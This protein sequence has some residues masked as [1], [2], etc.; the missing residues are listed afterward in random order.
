MTQQYTNTTGVGLSVA[1][2]LA[3]DSYAY[4]NDPF[5]I[6]ATSLL[7]PVRQ[8]IL[9][10]RMPEEDTPVT[11]LINV[12]ASRMGT[13]IH[14]S[15]EKVW[16]NNYREN[17][18]KLGYPKRVIDLVRVN[19]TPE[20]IKQYE[21][22][23][24]EIL[25][26]YTELRTKR[27]LGKWTISGEL[28]FCAEGAL[29]DFKSTKVYTYI[30]GTNDTK[31]PLQGSIYR[32]LNPIIVTNSTMKIQYIFTDW[33]AFELLKDPKN[34]PPHPILEKSYTL[35]S[36]EK[37]ESFIKGKLRDLE[38]YWDSPQE[39]IPECTD[40]DLWRKADVW[41]YYKNPDHAHVKG[42]RSTKNFDNEF[43]AIT[44]RIDDGNVGI[45]VHVP[46]E[47]TACKYCSVCL[48]CEQKDKY[49]AN[50]SLILKEAL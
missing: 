15:I 8:L 25:P 21:K 10:S 28:D 20:E 11:D 16:K 45:V 34:Y 2:W 29:E 14:D 48:T 5:T 30:H 7:K 46:G 27:K 6:S 35:M 23:G 38:K 13:A 40:E 19:P 33:K 47:V 43:D 50:G 39:D 49:V 44:R 36:P 18:E 1:V 12:A 41:K 22:D 24:E 17:L 42:K 9:A 3:H 32:W 37:T 31:Y 26:V 4:D